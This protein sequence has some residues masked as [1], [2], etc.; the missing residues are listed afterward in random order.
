MKINNKTVTE[1][2]LL[3]LNIFVKYVINNIVS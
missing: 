2:F 1:V 3:N